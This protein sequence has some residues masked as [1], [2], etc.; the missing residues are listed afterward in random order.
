MDPRIFA[1]FLKDLF[2]KHEEG[3]W[4]TGDVENEYTWLKQWRHPNAFR[5]EPK[6]NKPPCAYLKCPLCDHAGKI[7]ID[8]AGASPRK[9]TWSGIVDHVLRHFQS[10]EAKYE[11]GRRYNQFYKAVNWKPRSAELLARELEKWNEET[12][13]HQTKREIVE[14]ELTGH[15]LDPDRIYYAGHAPILG[16]LAAGRITLLSGKGRPPVA[17]ADLDGIASRLDPLPVD[18]ADRDDENSNNDGIS[19]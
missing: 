10:K 13:E 3:S 5:W 12:P 4:N 17:E 15:K 8:W 11:C 6:L 18:A 16:M 1:L 2:L 19:Y 7:M 9:V 14:L